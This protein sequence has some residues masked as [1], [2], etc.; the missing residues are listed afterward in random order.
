MRTATDVSKLHVQ[1]GT[2]R[3]EMKRLSPESTNVSQADTIHVEGRQQQPASVRREAG[4]GTGSYEH[5]MSPNGTHRNVGEPAASLPGGKV[6]SD[7]LVRGRGSQG[8]PAVGPAHSRGVSGVMPAVASEPLEGA[9]K[10]ASLARETVSQRRLGTTLATRLA[11]LSDYSPRGAKALNLMC[12]FSA[13]NLGQWFAE[14]RKNA[15]PGVDRMT[16]AAYDQNLEENLREL[17]QKLRTMSYRPQPVRR[18]Y[19]PKS[20]GKMRPLGIPAVEDKIVQQGIAT[21]LR[22][23]YEPLFLDSS[24]GFRPALSCHTALKVIDVAIMQRPTNHIIDADIRGFFDNVQHEWQMKML[25]LQIG[26]QQFLRLI[27]RFLKAGVIEAGNWQI[28]EGGTPQGGLISPVLSNIYLHYVLDLWFEKAVKP[29]LQGYAELIRYADDFIICVQKKEEATK[30]HQ[31]LGQ[32]LAKFGLELSAEKTRVI[33]FGRYAEANARRRG[34][35]PPTFDFLGFTHF[36]DKTRKGYYKLGRR[37]SAKKFRE[38]LKAIQAW[39]KVVRYAMPLRAWWP[40]FISKLR[41]HQRYYGVSGN[42][43]RVRAFTQQALHIA[44]KWVSRMSQKRLNARK[45]FWEFV[46]RHPVP[47]PQI[48]VNLYAFSGQRA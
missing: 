39:V 9:G 35:K 15:A 36:N 12:L 27:K 32:R 28:T 21:I 43:P 2:G 45:R 41:G 33:P 34:L 38:K 30:I 46:K 11:D 1:E 18:V 37:T 31:A 3:K 42:F 17:E 20:N 14:L 44:A 48:Y 40:L 47:S 23:I 7:N 4:A 13:A 10:E 5:G 6:A 26:D 29:K 16:V 25:E 8:L 19:I 24:H 22:A